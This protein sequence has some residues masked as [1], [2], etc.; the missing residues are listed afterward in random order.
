MRFG[1][2][3]VRDRLAGQ[4]RT[5]PVL[6][7]LTLLTGGLFK[8]AAFAREAF[9]ASR[10]GLTTVTDAYFALQQF[11]VTFASFMLGAFALAFAPAYAHARQHSDSVSWLPG[12]LLYCCLV[13]VVLTAIMLG[14]SP[15]LLSIFSKN[16]SH[17]TFSTLLI[18][19][20][21]FAPISCIGIWASI[22]TARGS[23]LWAMSMMGLAYLVM[24]LALFFLYAIGHL[25]N[26]SL[27]ISMAV[28]FSLVGFYSLIRILWS[29]PAPSAM[30]AVLFPW[31]NSEFRAFLRQLGASS[32]EN[33]GF[34]CNQLLLVYFLAQAGTGVVSANTCGMRIGLLGYS[35]LAQPLALLVQA[36]LCAVERSDRN[37]IFRRWMLIV[38]LGVLL[39][40]AVLY[41]F[42]LP[43]IRI[44]YMH[45]KFQAG[46]L[47]KVNLMLPA[48]IG[49]FVVMSLNSVVARYMFTEA[50]GSKY[51][52]RQL[53]AYAAANLLRLLFVGSASPAVLVWFS[54]MAEFCAFAW[55]LLTCLR[56]DASQGT[57]PVFRRSGEAY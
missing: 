27:P 55:N 11:P 4:N 1:V 9:I 17:D 36:R 57:L 12:L 30:A 2:T 21:S 7:G 22:C 33:G 34:A 48:W 18:L 37:S 39:L 5:A 23:N 14:A 50:K 15:F 6:I 24:T 19:S 53:I 8:L 16:A 45:G 28:G 49:Y 44:V 52:R 32:L 25:N 47:G 54:V 41:L 40:A 13:G 35:L 42:R 31:K 46:E 51:A 29:Q 20:F 38:S 3:A 10:F 43:I 26:L 56:S